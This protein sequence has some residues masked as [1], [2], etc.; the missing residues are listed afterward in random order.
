[1][2][3]WE[4][5]AFGYVL[6]SVYV[7]LRRRRDVRPAEALAV[8]V[9]T[10][11]PD[12]IDKPLAWSFDV[13]PSGIS[14]AH[15]LTLALPASV[16]ALVVGRRLDRRSAGA[17]FVVAY[18]SHLLG[19]ALYPFVWGHGFSLA[20]LFWPL[21]PTGSPTTEGLLSNFLYY[22]NSFLASLATPTGALYVGLEVTLLGTAL[23][24]W[25]SDGAPGLRTV[26]SFAR[27]SRGGD[28]PP[29]DAH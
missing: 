4:H 2:W 19:D 18:A 5:L 25:V 6:W 23:A 28:A 29:D 11:L 1:M 12:L 7:H 21:V 10:Q 14:L 8:A 13:L 16:A 20:F 26:L 24:L 22:L 3:P 27:G 17:A 9:G 15:S